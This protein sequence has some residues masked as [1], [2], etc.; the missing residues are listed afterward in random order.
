M[1]RGKDTSSTTRPSTPTP[2]IIPTISL[3]RTQTASHILFRAIMKLYTKSV[4]YLLI[5]SDHAAGFIA[6]SQV[7]QA[8]DV[9]G[10]AQSCVMDVRRER[11]GKESF[12]EPSGRHWTYTPMSLD[13]ISFFASPT[14]IV[15]QHNAS[16]VYHHSRWNITQSSP[17]VEANHEIS[18]S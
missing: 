14:I 8:T 9:D 15:C 12:F 17:V 16:P 11:N 10:P 6:K 18:S 5:S 1:G 4:I 7:S 13:P 3:S 2:V